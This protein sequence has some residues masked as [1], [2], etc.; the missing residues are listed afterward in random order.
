M[1]TLE[2]IRAELAAASAVTDLVGQRIRPQLL[3]PADIMPAVVITVVSEVPENSF[4]GTPDTRWVSARVQ[5][6]CYAEQYL[7]AHAVADAVNNVIAALSRP[8]L[9]AELESKQD[10]YEDETKRHRVS[11]D[12]MVAR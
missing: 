10:L 2:A 1:T 7:Q 12:F 11:M 8:D 3:Q 6:D 5:V 9:S 4:D